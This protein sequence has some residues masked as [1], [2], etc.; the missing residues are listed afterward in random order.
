MIYYDFL[1]W[2]LLWLWMTSTLILDVKGAFRS[3]GGFDA[4][5]YILTTHKQD[6]SVKIHGVNPNS[7]RFFFLWDRM[8][9]NHCNFKK[10]AA[11]LIL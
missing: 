10:K 3:E 5:K 11:E 1:F 9:L 8:E 6:F 2:F 4:H 7:R